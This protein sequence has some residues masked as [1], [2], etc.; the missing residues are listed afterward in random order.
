MKILALN[1]LAFLFF[2]CNA[3]AQSKKSIVKYGIKS[4]TETITE[5]NKTTNSTKIT[6]TK[7]GEVAEEIDYNKQ[8]EIKEIKRFVYNKNDK[9]VEEN[10]FSPAN[11]LIEKKTTKY[12][13]DGDKL[14]EVYYKGGKKTKSHLYIYNA[15]GL[16]IEK[17][18]LDEKGE[19]VSV[20]R[21]MYN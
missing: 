2:T 4:S 21:F 16:K 10:V 20:H 13:L 15:K 19:V 3:F 5:V 8:G 9:E 1:V 6:Y 14:E 7:T 17:R 18:T 11:V 12:N